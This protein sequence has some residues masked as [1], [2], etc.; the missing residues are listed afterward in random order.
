MPAGSLGCPRLFPACPRAPR[1]VQSAELPALEEACATFA[2][3]R[4]RFERL[5]ATRQQLAELLQVRPPPQ[6]VPSPSQHGAW[7]A[8]L[9]TLGPSWL[10]SAR[11]MLIGTGV[12]PP[13]C[14]LYHRHRL[15]PSPQRGVASPS[16]SPLHRHRAHRHP[17]LCCRSSAQ[18]LPAGAARGGDIPHGHGLQVSR[19]TLGGPWVAMTVPTSVCS[20]LRCGPLLQLCRGPLLRHTGLI[21]ALRVLTVGAGWGSRARPR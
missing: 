13:R 2:R 21:G 17:P 20:P 1:T 16:V 14:Y 3:A 9:G 8:S 5:E 6:S 10:G 12:T 19:G 7:E 15:G 4:H 11:V 18:Q